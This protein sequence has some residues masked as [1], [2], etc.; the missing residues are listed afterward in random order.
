M[1]D[2][3]ADSTH[4]SSSSGFAGS[5]MGDADRIATGAVME[6]GICWAVYDPTRGDPVWQIAPGTAF[7]DLPAHWSCPNCDA[8]RYKFMVLGES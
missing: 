6:C 2:A 3:M 8:P 5:T 1:I 7:A 4:D